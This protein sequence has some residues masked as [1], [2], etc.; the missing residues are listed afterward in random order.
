MGEIK[1]VIID[2]QGGHLLLQARAAHAAIMGGRP[3]DGLSVLSYGFSNE[4]STVFA[5]KWNKDS[6]RVYPQRPTARQALKDS[7]HG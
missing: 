5:V 3:A 4:P 7:T 6:V 2:Y 1:R